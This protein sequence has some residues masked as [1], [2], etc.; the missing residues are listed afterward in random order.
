MNSDVTPDFEVCS[1][2]GSEIAEMGYG[3]RPPR[4]AKLV[5]SIDMGSGPGGGDY[6]TYRLSTDKLRSC[7][8]LWLERSNYDSGKPEFCRVAV[9]EPYRGRSAEYAAAR[10]LTK[11]WEDERDQG[12][13]EP[14]LFVENEGVLTAEHIERISRAVFDESI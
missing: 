9:G 2:I 5:A 13:L 11:V 6:R 8:T 14:H 4:S 10:L 7:W 12:L 1:F 3:E